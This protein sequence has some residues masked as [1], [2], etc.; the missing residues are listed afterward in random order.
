MNYIFGD[1]SRAEYYLGKKSLRRLNLINIFFLKENDVIF[2]TR[3]WSLIIEI[4]FCS[5]KRPKIIFLADGLITDSNS[6][7]KHN[8][9]YLPLFKNIY[10]DKLLVRQSL[11]S[12]PNH[13][14]S[15]KVVS[16]ISYKVI[17]ESSQAKQIFFIFGNDPY[18]GISKSSIFQK[19]SMISSKVGKKIK[20]FYSSGNK[21]LENEIKQQ[22][23][24]FINH[25]KF[26]ENTYSVKDT[27]FITTPSTVSHE[28]FLLGASVIFLE[29]IKCETMNTLYL[30]SS[31]L[32]FEYD[33]VSFKFNKCINLQ[34]EPFKLTELSKSSEKNNINYE[35]IKAQLNFF[36]PFVFRR[37]LGEL[38]QLLFG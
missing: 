23:P 18:L 15:S 8:S 32:R 17:E 5:K 22:F 30:S 10:G 16:N 35:S 34:K 2:V 3:T 1:R 26:S 13:V 6:F 37:F 27:L 9:Y 4:I 25:G 19:L 21:K 29:G 11:D 31:N 38:R 12:L 28:I 20:I 33:T 24:Q 36:K 7:A 14:P